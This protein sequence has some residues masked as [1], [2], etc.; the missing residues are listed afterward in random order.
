[1]KLG[2]VILAAGLG[3]RMQS[4]LPKVLHPLAGRPLLDHVL[5]T[6]RGLAAE[7]IVIVHGH[8]GELVRE[9]LADADCRWVVQ[10][11]QL[12]TGHAVM[13]ALPIVNDMD[14]ILIL[15]G[16]VPL[17]TVATLQRLL[18]A[19][20]ET[21][22]GILTAELADPT[23]YGR[24]L[25]DPSGRVTGIVEQRDASPAQQAITEINSGFLVAERARLETWLSQV[26]NDN[27]QGEYYLTDI[28]ALAAREGV[29]I[30]TVQPSRL[31]EISGVNDRVQLATLERDYQQ[32]AAERLMRA[33]VTLA[34]P[35]RFD[36]RGRLHV[37][38]DVSID[39]NCVIEGEVWLA[40][41]VQIGPG[42]VLKDCRI[43]RG[44]QISAH[45]IIEGA[46]VGAEARIGP[47]A[48]LRPRTQL[49]DRTH[50]GNFVELKQTQLGTGSKANHLSY[51]GDAE[52]GADV[53]IG[54]GT[55]TCNYDG[56]NKWQ[57]TI[58]R[59][60]FIGSNSALVAPVR[61]GADATIG[62]G[63]VI[64][65]DAPAAE[66]TLT[67]AKQATIPGWQRPKKRPTP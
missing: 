49:A 43:G 2:V 42:C 59:G 39:I 17:I 31:A 40:E 46:L 41:G 32:Q 6:A 50:V 4:S 57:T 5:E 24:I 63:S 11:P 29:T 64:A 15:Y 25:R 54:A 38:Q 20:A 21:A 34:D 35:T 44:T 14:R 13:Q 60:A 33:G 26:G 18:E 58:E 28:T 56:A 7:A 22:L 10:H 65:R 51:L 48:R 19:S 47:F 66:L 23:G 1:M 53:N 8:G 27:R 9:R 55:I 45:S 12:G 61:I 30:A 36:L 3:K 62:A 67:R 16:D 37:E 52:I